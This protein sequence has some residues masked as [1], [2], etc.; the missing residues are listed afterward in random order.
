M[1]ATLA[2]RIIDIITKESLSDEVKMG[3]IAFSG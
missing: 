3:N 2:M 1:A